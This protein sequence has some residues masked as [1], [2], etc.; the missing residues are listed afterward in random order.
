MLRKLNVFTVLGMLL[1]FAAHGIMGSLKLMGADTSALKAA[2]WAGLCFIAAHIVITSILTEQTLY[3]LKRSGAGY[4]RNNLLF[5][6]RRIS[7]F[8]IVIPL[9]VHLFIFRSGDTSAF[10]LQPFT[11]PVLVFHILMIVTIAFHVITNIRP[12]L[13]SLGV[14]DRKAFSADMLFI[15]SVLMLIFTAAFSVYYMRWA[16]L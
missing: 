11:S 10:R 5:W 14:K 13:I 9:A 2:A 1:C 7:G 6:A 15:I 4:F 3:A 16:R 12:L 8:A